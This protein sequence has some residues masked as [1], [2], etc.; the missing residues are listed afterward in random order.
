MKDMYPTSTDFD[1]TDAIARV[2]HLIESKFSRDGRLAPL[3]FVLWRDVFDGRTRVEVPTDLS[4]LLR[5]EDQREALRELCRRLNGA[6][7]VFHAA[8]CW[9]PDVPE[10]P[11]EQQKIARLYHQGRLDEVPQCQDG[12]LLVLE[13]LG[14]GLAG[15]SGL[16][17]RG[18]SCVPRIARWEPTEVAQPF[19]YLE[20]S[21]TPSPGALPC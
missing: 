12:V 5:L 11:E 21:A 7:A 13:V 6:F 2:Q 18:E 16:I 17:E 4:L 20:D 10:N 3:G 1:R 19:S 9:M 14:D 8:E 15:W